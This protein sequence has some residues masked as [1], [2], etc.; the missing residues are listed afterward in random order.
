MMEQNECSRCVRSG[1]HDEPEYA[2]DG[3]A[4]YAMN[5]DNT[6]TV[7]SSDLDAPADLG[8]DTKRKRL[9]IPLFKENKVVILPF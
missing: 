3:S 1:V 5:K 8:I 6:F 2:W 4:I 7:V 9:L